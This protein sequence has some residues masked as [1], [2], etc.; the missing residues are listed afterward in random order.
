MK[1]RKVFESIILSYLLTSIDIIGG[2]ETHF[3]FSN[4]DYARIFKLL[5]LIVLILSIEYFI[6]KKNRENK[7]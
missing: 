1:K 7:K 3:N 5:I 4:W 6:K 2:F